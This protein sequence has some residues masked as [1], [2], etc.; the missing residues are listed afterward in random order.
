MHLTGRDKYMQFLLK[1][2]SILDLLPHSNEMKIKSI[3]EALS[4]VYILEKSLPI[5]RAA[6]INQN[7]FRFLGFQ[8]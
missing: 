6:C 7:R 3:Q 4:L 2:H 5:Y 1:E 8:A